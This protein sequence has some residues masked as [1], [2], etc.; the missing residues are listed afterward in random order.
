MKNIVL[1]KSISVLII[2][3]FFIQCSDKPADENEI[4]HSGESIRQM[5][6]DEELLILG[7]KYYSDT[8]NEAQ[9]INYAE[10]LIKNRYYAAALKLLEE[11]SRKFPENG[12]VHE[13]YK[14]ALGGGFIFYGHAQGTGNTVS[15]NNKN[16]ISDDTLLIVLSS[17]SELDQQIRI[18]RS[19]ANLYNMRGI[20]FLQMNNLNA[21]EFDFTRACQI[22]SAFFD[23]FYNT[24]YV[25]YLLDKNLEALNWIN[26]RERNIRYLNDTDKDII[27]N[28]RKVLAD[29]IGIDNN[30]FL[31]EKNKRLEKAKIYV[32]L[33]NYN[34]ALNKLN[35]AIL[36][37][38][39]FGDAYALRAMVN[40]YLDQKSDALKDLEMAEKLTGKSDT[41]LSK[42]IRG[43]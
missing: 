8:E 15:G 17:I 12:K 18:A 20:L 23:S 7:R 10:A 37:D 29:L 38:Q 14:D 5:N 3:I 25:K 27:M 9:A 43:K 2:C 36:N 42:M 4:R 16:F 34:L 35:S 33:K 13:L 41:P 32:K 19:D 26:T 24:I 22:D 1:I 30:T 11:I 31:D 6:T 28:L 40:Y 21:A 39:G